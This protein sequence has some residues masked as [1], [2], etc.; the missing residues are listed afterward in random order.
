M[1]AAGADVLS[2]QIDSLTRNNEYQRVEQILKGRLDYDL[3][4]ALNGFPAVNSGVASL[5][6]LVEQ[7]D[8]TP[9]QVR[10]STRDPRLL[11]EITFAA[12]ISAFEGGALS[13]NLPY[14][15][16]YHPAAS[17]QRWRYVDEL[18]A[19]YHLEHGVTIDREFFGVLTACLVPPVIAIAV[20]I[21][22]ALMAAAGGVKA[23]SVG[24][25]EQGN[26]AQDLAAI[27]VLRRLTVDYLG[28]LSHPDVYVGV[29]W[30]QY[31]GAF[32]TD[33]RKAREILV[34]SAKTAGESD[35]VRLMLKTWVEAIRVP[36]ESENRGSLQLVR[37]ACNAARRTQ[38]RAVDRVQSAE[39]ELLTIEV[40]A[41][42]DHAL[43]AADGD[44]FLA[45]E[46]AV[47]RGWIDVPFSP[48]RWN[49]GQVLPMRDVG[50]A[51]RM[52]NIGLLP[53]PADVRDE[54]RR[55]CVTRTTA[56]RCSVEELIER[57]IGNII[58]GDFDVWP[59]A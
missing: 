29:V 42:V 58:R 31:M 33:A 51:V 57:D 43:E 10:H 56:E 52:A 15:R 37:E 22:E 1:H 9:F 38:I 54:H 18:S 13:Y 24:Y 35:A 19:M 46:I 30:H 8:D 34:G 47:A 39:E 23:I 3:S 12:G 25:S 44:P 16:D 55:L 14:Y 27:A 40:R 7:F 21:L 53:F 26:R 2:F 4:K 28:A 45:A 17:I 20:N 5:A 6:L 49:A 32:P 41:I 36:S 50:R 59:L 48:S 11:A